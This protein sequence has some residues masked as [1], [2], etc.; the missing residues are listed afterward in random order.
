MVTGFVPYDIEPATEI[1]SW[2]TAICM[3]VGLVLNAFVIGSMASALSTMDSKK[4][5]AAGKLRTIE[6]YLQLN[7][8]APELRSHILEFYEYL[9]T[10]T[11]SFEDLK[12]YQ[13]LPPSLATKLAITVHKRVVSR[14]PFFVALSDDAVL[15]VLA[16]LTAKIFVP[17]QLIVA[18]GAP[19][20]AIYF[21]KKG[22]VAVV[23]NLG[24]PTMEHIEELYAQNDNFGFQIHPA[25]KEGR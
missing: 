8:V 13:E 6:A 24:V 18:E 21:I 16:R 5:L 4:A 10:S 3:F 12:L 14:A 2:F 17:S 1:E 22:K 7:S 15:A 19:L 20:K 9:Y 25:K 23:S 11:Q